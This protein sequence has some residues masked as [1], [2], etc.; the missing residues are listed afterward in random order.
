MPPRRCAPVRSPLSGG[1]ALSVLLSPG[2]PVRSPDGRPPGL[3]QRQRRARACS[4]RPSAL[5]AVLTSG[6][7]G[8]PRRQALTVAAVLLA[9]T[10]VTGSRAAFAMSAGLVLAGR[11]PRPPTR[12]APAWS[13]RSAQRPSRRSRRSRRP[14]RVASAADDRAVCGAERPP[15]RALAG[16][17]RPRARRALERGRRRAF[18]DWRRQP[19]RTPT[20]AWAH[21]AWLQQAAETGLVG[22]LP[23][24]AI[25]LVVMLGRRRTTPCRCPR[26]APRR[27]R[28]ACRPPSTTSCTSRSITLLAALLCGTVRDSPRTTG[29]SSDEPLTPLPRTCEPAARS[30][31]TP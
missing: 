16:R 17:R 24:A 1:V 28:A 8:P 22:G 2:R 13:L 23:P 21:S 12:T 25:A 3:R 7:P 10:H 26:R 11:G 15:A 14:R 30:A 9:L 5:L 27:S 18:A 29:Q 4:A 31:N 19:C 6:R 20:P